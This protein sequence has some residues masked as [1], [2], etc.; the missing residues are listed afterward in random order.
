MKIGDSIGGYRV[1]RFLVGPDGHA[2]LAD[3]GIS[4]LTILGISD[5]M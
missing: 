1:L 4:R 3:F 2:V 5:I